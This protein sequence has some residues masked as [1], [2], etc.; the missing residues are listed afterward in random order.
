M[1]IYSFVDL[2]VFQQQGSALTQLFCVLTTIYTGSV[3]VPHR[4]DVLLV[5]YSRLTFDQISS[6]KLVNTL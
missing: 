6:Y 1:L 3:N 4:V 5:I 2:N